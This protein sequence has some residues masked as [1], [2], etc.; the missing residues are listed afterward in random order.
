ML[1]LMQ[2]R[3]LTVPTLL[4]HAAVYHA[5]AEIVSRTV[6]GPIHRY[7]YGEA[8]RR[9]RRLA[10]ALTNLGVGEGSVLGSLSWNHYRHFELYYGVTGIGAALHTA[11]PRLFPE[12][13]AYTINHAGDSILFFDLGCLELVEALREDLRGVE[14][15]VAL[16]DGAHMPN[17]DLP[18]LTCY[19]DLLDGANDG[20]QWPAI[21]ERLG[22]NICYTSGTTGLP[23]G[24]LYSH[25][26]TV[27][28]TWTVCS[29][30]GLGLCSAD[31]VLAAAPMFHCNG[32]TAPYAGPMTGAKLVFPG[33]ALDSASLHE[34]IEAEGVTFAGGVPTVWLAMLE[35]LK[36]TG[37]R[38]DSLQRIICGGSA[39][40]RAMMETL[41]N[42]YGV[43]TIHAWGMTET[44][45]ACTYAVPAA[46]AD[47]AK[48]WRIRESQGR[49]TYGCEMRIVDDAGRDLPWDGRSIGHFRIRGH[50]IAG[51]YLHG[52]GG[53]V[54]D[55]DGW[56]VTG[57]VGVID[58]DGYIR[59]TDR[60]KDAIKS[61]GEWIS[62]IALENAAV[63]HPDVMEAAVIGIPHPKW[64]ERPLLI[65]VPA[66][67]KELTLEDMRA[68][69]ADKV[70]KW[71]LPDQML[72]VDALPHTATGKV[73]KA[74]L[75]ERYLT[76]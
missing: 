74:A 6:E 27:L 68:F 7:G 73:K 26:G 40:P 46:G 64:Q 59:I 17:V 8:E 60:A 23:K 11:N 45:A 32:W 3:P 31:V 51:T 30:N 43:T 13:I 33:R 19:E 69:L 54:L 22:T 16:T 24:A 10:A 67:G 47:E 5:E 39:P 48:S 25:R 9:A 61:G 21:D 49:P 70:A 53:A 14:R 50:W 52:A 35:Y 41:Q 75:R 12:Q 37:K 2:D 55:D 38:L 15:Y 62:T 1:G 44:T 29:P 18:N 57:D 76:A 34:L 28:Q 65:V 63:A 72:C 71:W 42:D 36:E 66:E 20:F 56:L 58:A 4:Q